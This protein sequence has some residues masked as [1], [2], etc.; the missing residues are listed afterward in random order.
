MKSARALMAFAAMAASLGSGCVS[1]PEVMLINNSGG[2]LVLQVSAEESAKAPRRDLIVLLKQGASRTFLEGPASIR[3]VRVVTDNCLNRYDLPRLDTR[4]E[5]PTS[6][7][8]ARAPEYLSSPVP[9]RIESDL[10]LYL[11]DMRQTPHGGVGKLAAI[12]SYGF[13]LRPTWAACH[14]PPRR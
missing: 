6:D 10:R 4:M 13:P 11:A 8:G 5:Q 9:I 7:G 2:D 12:Q 1:P 14:P 3:G